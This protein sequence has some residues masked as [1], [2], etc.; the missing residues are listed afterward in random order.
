VAYVLYAEVP[1]WHIWVGALII[2]GSSYFVVRSEA[3]AARRGATVEAA[4]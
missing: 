4:E 1:G 2:I 3:R